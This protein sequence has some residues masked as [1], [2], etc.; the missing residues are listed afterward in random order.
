MAKLN[1]E[2]RKSNRKISIKTSMQ[3]AKMK[4]RALFYF[5]V[6]LLSIISGSLASIITILVFLA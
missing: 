6:I 2:R 4:N 5:F 3:G 1:I